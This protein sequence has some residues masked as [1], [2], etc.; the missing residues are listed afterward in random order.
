MNYRLL[1]ALIIAGCLAMT[2][3]AQT[4]I[5][6]YGALRGS[7]GTVKFIG[8]DDFE[9][10]TYGILPA[11]GYRFAPYFRTELE[12]AARTKRKRSDPWSYYNPHNDDSLSGEDVLEDVDY[13]ERMS[14][15]YSVLS[16]MAQCYIDIP[17]GQNP[18]QPF[19]NVGV[20]GTR[21]KLTRPIWESGYRDLDLDGRTHNSVS[22]SWN[23]G[24]GLAYIYD[25]RL[26]LEAM[27][28]Y[29]DLGRFK[30][31]DDG[32]KVKIQLHDFIIGARFA[33]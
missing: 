22:V 8:E 33:F 23:A 26:S 30:L 13:A 7:A 19:V 2:L 20:G 24:A 6:Y 4:A 25:D 14:M 21:G 32:T 18:I 3:Q 29:S 11:I 17:L 5:G 15:T 12:F 28:R 31:Y 27:Y 1:F 16:L 10:G 9:V